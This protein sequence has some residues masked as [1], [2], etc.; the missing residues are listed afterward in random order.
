[1]HPS[2][3]ADECI[4]REIVDALRGQGFTVLYVAEL[5]SSI[6]D[7]EVLAM[8]VAADALLITSDK[9]FGEIVFRQNRLHSGVLLIRLAGVEP[10][11]KAQLT[12]E[13]LRERTNE[14]LGNFS[15]LERDHL[16]VRRA[17]PMPSNASSHDQA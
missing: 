14:L 8:A 17:R 2:L 12:A 4:D 9:D 3:L 10:H 13:I 7:D 11:V 15:V 1:M 6:P 5:A 16:R